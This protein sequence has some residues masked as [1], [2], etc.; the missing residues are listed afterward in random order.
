LIALVYP[1]AGSSDRAGGL[2]DGP[3]GR[4]WSV[5]LMPE[6]RITVERHMA[7][8]AGSVWALFADIPNL[9]NHWNGLRETRAIGDQTRGVGARRHV[10]L[11]PIGSVE[12][13]VT[14]WEEGRRLDTE[15]R[16]SLTVPFRR[17]A[18]AL[19][20]EA[21][22][23]GTR[24]TFHYRFVPRGGPLGRLIGPLIEKRLTA[25]FRD[26]LAAIES[27]ALAGGQR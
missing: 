11:K 27:A 6:R 23:E 10:A 20:L 15:N 12:E 18:S 16:P 24:A 17:A 8:S 3:A 4:A 19:T 2:L 26:M 13:T 22:S 7:A 1:P 14:V 25:T 5:I 9:A 21:D